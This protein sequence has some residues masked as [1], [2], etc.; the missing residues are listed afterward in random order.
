MCITTLPGLWIK[1]HFA[2]AII[3]QNQT[4]VGDSEFGNTNRLRSEVKSN[5]AR[6]SGHGVKGLNRNSKMPK[7]NFNGEIQPDGMRCLNALVT[8]AFRRLTPVRGEP[9]RR[10]E[11]D[12][13]CRRFASTRLSR[14][15]IR[16]NFVI[17]APIFE[18]SAGIDLKFIV[19]GLSPN[20]ILPVIAVASAAPLSVNKPDFPRVIDLIQRRTDHL[21]WQ[22]FSIGRNICDREL[23]AGWFSDR[24]GPTSLG[25]KY[26]P[27][28]DRSG[29]IP[30]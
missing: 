16:A 21:T 13:N 24:P 10:L 12:P 29:A 25:A 20:I 26:V 27:E 5:Q 1:R 9:K 14:K 18:R 8:T 15:W 3:H 17:A 28:T 4:A 11:R 2:Q 19:A 7:Q 23:E 30:I 22:V 6:R